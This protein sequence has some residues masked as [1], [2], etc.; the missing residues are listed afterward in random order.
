MARD[1][2]TM[3]DFFIDEKGEKIKLNGIEDI[4]LIRD[5]MDKINYYDDKIIRTKIKLETGNVVEYQDDLYIVISEID[6]NQKSYRGRIRRINYPIKIVVDEE[7][8]EFNTIIEGI[9][10]GID[11]G[12]FMNLQDGKIQVT[13]PADIISNR[14]GVDMR[15]I[16]MGTAWKVVGVDKSKLGLITLYCEKDS[17]GVND[18]KENEIADKDKI[19]DPVEIHGNYNITINGSDMIYYGRERE[20]TATVTIVDT[21]EVVEDKEVIWSLDAPNNNAAIISQE[22]GKCVVLGGNTYGKVNLKCELVDDGEI[23][24]IKEIT[25][26]SIL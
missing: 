16:K 1:I 8:C 26:R 9:S 13:L 7:I 21:G 25:I 10:F 18:D 3:L 5:A 22:D 6:Q 19:V 4:A 23:Y 20:F 11:E 24:S 17:F 2:E 14:I 15:F 12:K